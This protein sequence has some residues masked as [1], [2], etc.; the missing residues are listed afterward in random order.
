MGRG[1]P[2]APPRRA[3]RAETP[4][5]QPPIAGVR[6]PPEALVAR[7]P[8][9]RVTPVQAPPRGRRPLHAALIMAS[10]LDA[11]QARL[12]PLLDGVGRGVAQP[13]MAYERGEGLVA[14]PLRAT[15]RKGGPRARADIAPV[16]PP[17]AGPA[18]KGRPQR[19]PPRAPSEGLGPGRPA[20]A[21]IALPVQGLLGLSNA[22]LR[23]AYACSAIPI[24]ERSPLGRAETAHHGHGRALAAAAA[25]Q[26]R[27]VAGRGPA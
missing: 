20:R 13:P 24:P 14:E 17:L 11:G 4:I 16:R 21:R 8:H 12:L 26:V 5:P 18:P 15:P 7:P 25:W 3:T 10:A 1:E 2:S 9:G 27:Q 23:V 22:A 6:L 19:V